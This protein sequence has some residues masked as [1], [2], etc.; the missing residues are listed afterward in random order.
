[1]IALLMMSLL[2]FKCHPMGYTWLLTRNIIRSHI[3]RDFT[4]RASEHVDDACWSDYHFLRCGNY[5]RIEQF[6]NF[7]V[8]RHC[9][10]AHGHGQATDD[11]ESRSTIVSDLVF[12]TNMRSKAGRWSG[13]AFEGV[14]NEKDIRWTVR[15]GPLH[16]NLGLSS[17]GQVG[18]FPEQESNWRWIM[19]Q[20]S[21]LPP[22]T[23]KRV[24]NGFAYTGG[25]TMAAVALNNQCSVTSYNSSEFIV[26]LLTS[27]SLLCFSPN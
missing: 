7:I 5:E 17:M 11:S 22:D 13:S 19:E 20:A 10:T 9:P 1:M 4:M 8:T 2:L 6:G 14:A 3:L 21:S 26:L 24:F 15:F 27:R 12:N 25:S 23:K 18:V 16:F